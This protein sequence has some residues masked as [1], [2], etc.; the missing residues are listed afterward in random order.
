MA[1]KEMRRTKL[2]D[3]FLPLVMDFRLAKM[4]CTQ[5]TMLAAKALDAALSA[6]G[7][8]LRKALTASSLFNRG[9]FCKM[10]RR[11]SSCV[12]WLHMVGRSDK[13]PLNA[14]DR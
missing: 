11:S 7:K 4:F 6:P 10:S 8:A 13:L 14:L 5:T 9:G 1:A 2:G 12:S 3:N